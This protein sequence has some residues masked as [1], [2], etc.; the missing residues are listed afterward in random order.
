MLRQQED[1]LPP[2]TQRR[3]LQ[4][5]HRQPMVQIMAQLPGRKSSVQICLGS[6]D[7]LDVDA[8]FCH[9]T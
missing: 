5:D 3:N 6:G 9:R 1:T 2:L 4:D 7:E 8:L